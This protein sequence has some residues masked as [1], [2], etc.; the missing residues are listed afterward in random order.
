MGIMGNEMKQIDNRILDLKK[1]GY[2]HKKIIQLLKKEFSR[3]GITEN[4]IKERLTHIESE[5]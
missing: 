3:T 4:E 5:L 1:R 2:P